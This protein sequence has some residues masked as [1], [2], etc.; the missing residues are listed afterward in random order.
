MFSLMKMSP[1]GFLWFLLCGFMTVLWGSE[2]WCVK[3]EPEKYMYLWG[4]EGPVA[5]LWYYASE[6][7]YVLHL[8]CLVVWFLSGMMLCV[9][10][11]S[12]KKILLRTHVCLTMLW[13][14]ARSTFSG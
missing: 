2:V 14:A 8:A 9:C 13:L 12:C 1:G 6:S 4:G 3:T 7:L 11:W 5:H 10:R